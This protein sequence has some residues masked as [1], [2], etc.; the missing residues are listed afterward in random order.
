MIISTSRWGVWV[1]WLASL[2]T[3]L[4]HSNHQWDNGHTY[5][6]KPTTTQ[7]MARQSDEVFVS[8]WSN[9]TSPIILGQSYIFDYAFEYPVPQDIK[10]KHAVLMLCYATN[11]ANGVSSNNVWEVMSTSVN[12]E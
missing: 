8:T 7:K 9:F 12:C 6:D 3:A 5:N 1:V 10:N 11:Y 4:G 2:G